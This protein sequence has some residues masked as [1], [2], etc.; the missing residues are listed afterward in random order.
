MI[1]RARFYL[2]LCL[3]CP[4]NNGVSCCDGNGRSDCV[5]LSGQ[6]FE[7]LDVIAGKRM[8]LLL[9]VCRK[10]VKFFVSQK[11]ILK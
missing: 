1:P 2:V 7:K 3:L 4:V 6:S 10:L 11:K 9:T 5:S 8:R